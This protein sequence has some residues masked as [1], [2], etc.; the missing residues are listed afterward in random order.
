YNFIWDDFCDWYIEM[1]KLP[2]YG[3]DEAAKKTTRSILAYVLDQTMRLLHPFMPF[4]TEEI[5]QH[6]PHQGESITVSQW[7]VVVP[8][9]TDTEAAADMKLLVELIRSVRNIRSEVNTP[10]SKQVELYIKTSTDEIA[11]RLEANRSYVERFTNPSVLKIGTDIEAVDKA[12]TAVVSGAE[13][14]LPLEGLINIDE[15]IARLQK[16]FDKLT[17]EV[18][19]VQKKLGNEGFMKKAPAHVI[20]EERE[21]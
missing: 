19:R 3:E 15:E 20:D 4:L 7:P 10:M 17:K 12:M 14:I 2:L 16:E 8:E 5:W 6:L 13:V 21:K 9:H 1:A 18:E 11:A